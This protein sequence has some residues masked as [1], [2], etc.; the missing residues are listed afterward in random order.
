MLDEVS[1]DI[2]LLAYFVASAVKAHDDVPAMVL[3]SICVPYSAY[4][5]RQLRNSSF[6]IRYAIRY[7]IRDMVDVWG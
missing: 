3:V 2:S 4:F 1:K 7:A 5:S 6:M